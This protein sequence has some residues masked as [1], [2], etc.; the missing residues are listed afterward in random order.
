MCIIIFNKFSTVL[1]IHKTSY[2]HIKNIQNN[3]TEFF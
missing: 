1:G 2:K 3:G